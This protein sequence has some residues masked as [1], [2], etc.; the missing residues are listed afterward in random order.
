MREHAGTLNVQKDADKKTTAKATR[1]TKQAS[2]LRKK[3]DDQQQRHEDPDT[4]QEKG[5]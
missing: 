3:H 5:D 4:D 1:G 2:T